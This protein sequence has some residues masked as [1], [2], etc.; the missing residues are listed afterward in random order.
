MTPQLQQAI[1]L[2]Q[3]STL[4]LQTEIQDVLDS[5]MMLELEDESSAPQDEPK[6]AD[7][8]QTAESKTEEPEFS[9]ED[10]SNSAD[11]IP[12]DLPVDTQWDDIYDVTTSYSAPSGDGDNRDFFENQSGD[13][14]DL[15]SHLRWQME[16]TPWSDLDKAIAEIIIE[17]VD[18]D[19]YLT[20]ELDDILN[21]FPENTENPLEL[22]EIEAVLHRIQQ[23]DPLGVASRNLSEALMI[24]LRKL[25][26][27]TPLLAETKK[28][29]DQYLDLLGKKQFSVLKRRLKLSDDQLLAASNLIKTLNP[30]PGSAL[31]SNN[32]QYIA[33]DVYV[34][35]YEDRWVVELN[36]ESTPKIRLNN[37]Y[38]GFV[39][40]GDSSDDNQT[41]KNHLQ[42]AR[43]FIKSLQSR[44]ETLLKVATAIVQKQ[45]DFFE[46]GEVGMK[47]LVLREIAETVE[48]HESTISRITTS[49][50]MHTPRGV[51]EFKYFFSSHVGTD[52]G[53][54]ASA[55]A[56]R[57]RIKTLISEETPKK[58]LSDNKIASM[59]KEEGINVARRT[60]AKY[61]EAM[62]IP[63]SNERKDL[64]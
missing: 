57:A 62:N 46:Q 22:D 55:T 54:E 9:K 21:A 51:F 52:D 12:E 23:F 16:L 10:T 38:A 31:S 37:Y 42:E 56:I 28:L 43:W 5:N 53:G 13:S 58:P 39:K 33:P 14:E 26:A 36:A 29:V 19:G 35:K 11:D 20:I 27:D 49:K 1:R 15:I 45:H 4:E 44:N 40:R 30:R 24:Q 18:E 17:A 48:M 32:A 47:P 7:N 59:L 41:L 34:R 50:Y 6:S 61:R 64:S 63:P 2:L 3:L 25:P 60:V 8:D